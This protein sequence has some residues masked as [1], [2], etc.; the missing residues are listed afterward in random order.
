MSGWRGF[1]AGQV[2]IHGGLELADF[3]RRPIGED[4]EITWV[5]GEHLG[6]QGLHRP[7]KIFHLLQGLP[8]MRF[9]LNHNSPTSR[10][11]IRISSC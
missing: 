4:G 6:A 2:I 10:S 1:E 7:A 9:G 5:L 8:Q 11:M 3:I